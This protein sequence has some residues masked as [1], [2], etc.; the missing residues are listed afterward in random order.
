MWASLDD[1]RSG[2]ITAGEFGK[3]MKLGTPESYQVPMFE[4]RRIAS[5]RARASLE[6]TT[7]KLAER[8]M[9]DSNK[10]ANQYENEVAQL[11]Q[12]LAALRRPL[13][14][15]VPH[16]P[17]ARAASARARPAAALPR[18]F[19]DAGPLPTSAGPGASPYLAG[20]SPVKTASGGEMPWLKEP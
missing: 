20:A 3:F 5:A 13:S 16:P 12:E 7:A 19:L 4:R 1:D 2:F 15:R 11:G 8:Q 9:V 14:A 18:S 6:M 17:P 10:L